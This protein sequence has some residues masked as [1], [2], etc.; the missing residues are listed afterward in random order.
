MPDFS[1]ISDLIGAV[2]DVLDGVIGFAGSVG[3][4]GVE[5]MLGLLG[6]VDIEP[7]AAE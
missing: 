7:P 1:A 2:K 5:T 4:D 6:S 3:G